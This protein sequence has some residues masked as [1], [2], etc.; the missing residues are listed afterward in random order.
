V[1]RIVLVAAVLGV[2]LALSAAQAEAAPVDVTVHT[3][4]ELQ[5]AIADFNASS[6][7]DATTIHIAAGT[8]TLADEIVV[9]NNA[10]E[11][12]LLGA[13]ARTT[14]VQ[15]SGQHR[16]LHLGDSNHLAEI[17]DVTITGGHADGLAGGGILSARPLNLHRDTIA[18]NS[19]QNGGGIASAAGGL[20]AFDS[21][22]TGNSASVQNTSFETGGGAIDNQS[23]LIARNVTFSGNSVDGTVA[24]PA[25]GGAIRSIPA[26]PDSE[27]Y[28]STFAANSV[29]GPGADGRDLST[30]A[31]HANG[32][33][34]FYVTAN[35]NIFASEPVGGAPAGP[36][37]CIGPSPTGASGDET[38]D[39]GSSCA[40]HANID[41]QLQPLAN[42]GGPTDTHALSGTSPAIDQTGDCG[43]PPVNTFTDQ[44]GLPRP[45]A[46]FQCDS[47]A[48]ELQA[49]N[50]L[51]VA[52]SGAPNPVTSG[53]NAMFTITVSATGPAGDATEPTVTVS[54]PPGGVLTPSQ[55]SCSGGTCSLGAVGNGSSATVTL[56]APAGTPGTL[57]SSASVSGP[58]PETSAANNSAS[59][60]VNVVAPATVHPDVVPQ[61]TRLGLSRKRFRARQGT[62]VTYVLSQ[63]ANVR[64]TVERKRCKPVRKKKRRCVWRKTGKSFTRA[65]KQGTNSFTFKRK[66]K[67]GRYRLVATVGTTRKRATFR[68]VR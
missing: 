3:V 57:T 62:R 67:P 35:S 22:F 42:N 6:S 8:Y 55:G 61:V 30:P 19:A 33:D 38:F 45:V 12:K 27:I 28:F 66:L 46:T 40:G 36:H 39:T 24:H 48:Y 34:T 9:T 59:A 18:G 60:S 47:G 23:G 50:D 41:P 20:G 25:R 26:A 2:T 56:V 10:G 31:K 43:A 21:T 52:I 16:V 51:A 53:A 14:V 64:F 17:D 5:A 32:I 4:A 63:A 29:T 49:G 44:R 65:G 7:D 1:N 68:I 54:L 13:G 58:R 15:A 37:N 11:L